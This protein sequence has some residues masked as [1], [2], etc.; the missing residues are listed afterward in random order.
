[1]G[2]STG[3]DRSAESAQAFVSHAFALGDKRSEIAESL[4]T[5]YGVSRATAYRMIARHLIGSGDSEPVDIA[6]RDDG[7]IDLTA[8]AERQYAAA[9]AA[10]DAKSALRWFNVLQR[11]TP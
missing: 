2:Q 8:E 7:T 1:M 9:V 4:Q 5:Y 11:L 3:N 6:R 10:D